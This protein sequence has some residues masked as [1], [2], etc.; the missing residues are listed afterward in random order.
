MPC[1]SPDPQP[2]GELRGLAGG[3]SRPTSRG[4]VEGSRGCLPG[5]LLGGGVCPK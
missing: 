1:R 2:G 5:G 3:V 4:E